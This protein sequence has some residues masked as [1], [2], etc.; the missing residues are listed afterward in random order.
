MAL[1]ST[2]EILDD[3]KAG[4]MVILIDEEDRENE[5][6]LLL[7]GDFVTP[8]AI[9]FMARHARGLI[10]LTLT[11]ERCRQLNLPLMTT[12][13]GTRTGTNFTLSIEAAEG[14]TTGISAADRARTVQVAVARDAR[15]LDL[16]QP[17]HIFPVMARDGGVLV[18]AGHTEAGCDLGALAGLTPAAVICEIMKDDGTMARLPDLL[19]FS[20]QHGLKIGTIADLIHYRSAN[21]TLVERLHQRRVTTA[22][23]EFDLV[24]YRDK[25]SG[26]PHLALV[27]GTIGADREALVRVHE[28]LSPLDLLITDGGT[29]SWS[30]HRALTEIHAHGEGALVMLNCAQSGESLLAQ[31]G[32]WCDPAAA[33]G[34][35][36]PRAEAMDLRTYG[37]GAQIL[38]DLGVRRMRLLAH[39]RRMPSMTGF[40]LEVTGFDEGAGGGIDGPDA[41][42]ASASGVAL[43]SGRA[44]ET[45]PDGK[46]KDKKV[47]D[48]RVRHQ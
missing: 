29:H 37:I 24:V 40:N 38:R 42:R 1:A 12:L 4:K 15:P 39:P 2:A 28:P 31:A 9:N 14:V 20:E 7:A 47:Q 17:G 19:A 16:V 30:V 3:F 11:Q 22:C 21:E 46:V 13:N 43:A 33:D 48:K 44:S 41:A 36:R 8:E 6:D 45:M 5:G 27:A 23:G 35:L 25:P 32:S 26:Q 34:R 10:C 18:R